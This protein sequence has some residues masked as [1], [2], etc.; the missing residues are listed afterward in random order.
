MSDVATRCVLR[1]VDAPK[2]KMRLRPG[3]P[4]APQTHSWIWGRGK[5]KGEWKGLGRKK[6]Q[7]GKERKGRETEK[8]EGN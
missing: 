3:H 8:E 5:G 4:R 2:L 6:E 7:N 1:P